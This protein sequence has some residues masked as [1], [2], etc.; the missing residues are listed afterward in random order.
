VSSTCLD[1]KEARSAVVST[2]LNRRDAEPWHEAALDAF[3][4]RAPPAHIERLTPRTAR[5][6]DQLDRESA[7]ELDVP[8]RRHLDL[9]RQLWRR[10]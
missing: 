4:L 8:G 10:P 7:P 6:R 2:L 3:A 1:V 5:P 9:S